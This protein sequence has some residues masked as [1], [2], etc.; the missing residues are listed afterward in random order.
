MFTKLKVYDGY[1]ISLNAGARNDGALVYFDGIYQ[2][3][4]NASNL[5]LLKNNKSYLDAVAKNV[6]NITN[7]NSVGE[8]NTSQG[9]E[10][11]IDRL[12]F[13]QIAYAP[14]GKNPSYDLSSDFST[15]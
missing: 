1:G 9:E 12:I 13:E 10:D 11:V 4:Q 14:F 15:S 5:N 6:N 8:N 2:V 7:V 3:Q